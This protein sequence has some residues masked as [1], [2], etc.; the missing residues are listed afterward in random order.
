MRRAQ[1][2]YVS[3]LAKDLMI[4]NFFT[5][6]FV[7]DDELRRVRTLSQS[8]QDDP[9]RLP[10]L[11]EKL[12]SATRNV[13]LLQEV[14]SYI[15]EALA[16]TKLPEVP[17]DGAGAQMAKV[18]SLESLHH[19]LDLRV[20]DLKK[21][22]EGANNKVHILQLQVAA[23]D[24]ATL[25]E[26]VNSI[27]KNFGSLVAAS[28]AAQRSSASIELMNVR[29][30]WPCIVA[31]ACLGSPCG[32]WQII[33]SG[34]FAFDLIDRLSGDD[35]LGSVGVDDSRGLRWL[36]VGVKDT[37]AKWP[38]VWFLVNMLWLFCVGMCLRKLMA[39]L[40][41][42]AEGAKSLRQVV[43]KYVVA[44]WE[45]PTRPDVD[46][47]AWC[48]ISLRKLNPD[49]LQQ[50]LSV[51]FFETEDTSVDIRASLKQV[52]TCRL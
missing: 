2:A 9:T 16:E 34:S 10:L 51:R 44:L 13:I 15:A 8:Y 24:K 41:R 27:D 5:R 43:N 18:L 45:V 48:L 26:T 30:R 32:A 50:F 12:Q 11:R 52:R 33:F 42:Q 39:Y 23:I 47:V 38:M 31:L 3:L 20:R 35:F 4:K 25:E 19:D 6:T 17:A 7:L 36:N 21:L 46:P 40:I 37:F 49:A 14:L 29:D 22:M 28:A 1:I